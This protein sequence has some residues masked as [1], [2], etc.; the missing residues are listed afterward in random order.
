MRITE[1]MV[2][3]TFAQFAAVETRSRGKRRLSPEERNFARQVREG[4]GFAG[5]AQIVNGRACIGEIG[6]E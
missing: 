4:G 2:G 3:V 5:V 1:D 6:E